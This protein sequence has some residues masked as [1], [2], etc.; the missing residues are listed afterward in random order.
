MS[1]SPIPS[2]VQP[3]GEASLLGFLENVLG[4]DLTLEPLSV[5]SSSP[6]NSVRSF[7]WEGSGDSSRSR[8]RSPLRGEPNLPERV[9]S[10]NGEI[11]QFPRRQLSPS[12]RAQLGA[13]AV[14]ETDFDVTLTSLG[15]ELALLSVSDPPIKPTAA[16]R[17]LRFETNPQ[18][19]T[20]RGRGQRG[21]PRG[22]RPRG[23]YR[24]NRG[25]TPT[26]RPIPRAARAPGITRNS[27]S[28]LENSR[29]FP[30]QVNGP[31]HHQQVENREHIRHRLTA[32]GHFR[33]EIPPGSRY[34]PGHPRLRYLFSAAEREREFQNRRRAE[35][36]V[37]ISYFEGDE[38]QL[39]P[40]RQHSLRQ[41]NRQQG[42]ITLRQLLLRELNRTL[43]PLGSGTR[44]GQQ[45]QLERD[46]LNLHHQEVLREQ[47][48]IET[49]EAD[50]Y[51]R[52][53]QV[54]EDEIALNGL[55]RTIRRTHI[56]DS[57]SSTS[58]E[59]IP[60][61]VEAFPTLPT[62]QVSRVVTDQ[63]VR[64]TDR[65]IVIRA[66]QVAQP[67]SPPQVNPDS[68]ANINWPP[69][70]GPEFGGAQAH[71]PVSPPIQS[72][73]STSDSDES[74]SSSHRSDPSPNRGDPDRS[75]PPPNRGDPD[76]N[77]FDRPW[78]VEYT[79]RNTDRVF[80]SRAKFGT[81]FV[82]EME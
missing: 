26:R 1:Q 8:S 65:S 61:L 37:L 9:L 44:T 46:I 56:P 79:D 47:R 29:E 54:L 80:R 55:G 70:D 45:I 40:A 42:G 43:Q 24:G 34:P 57:W 13:A 68:G 23:S 69:R 14:V 41:F 30:Q 76:Q 67:G 78:V 11:P 64:L 33:S 31:L 22:W 27:A 5:R 48:T 50:S 36:R 35:L 6:V 59:S 51:R 38:S 73:T 19:W 81:F 60:D 3:L 66:P 4:E 72:A 25:A 20:S 52:E 71:R 17:P 32:Q 21:Q 58:S 63:V 15:R 12:E 28:T 16:V 18:S 82:W 74:E 10:P 2:E 7:H 62:R 49:E 75:G 53:R 77:N 39:S